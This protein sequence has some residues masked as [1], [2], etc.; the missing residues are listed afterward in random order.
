MTARIVNLEVNDSGAWRRVTSFDL[1]TK[2][3]PAGDLEYLT[4][5][6]FSLSSNPKLKARIIAPGEVAPLMIWKHGDMWREWRE[7]A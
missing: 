1:D 7:V 2:F 5:S 6:L 4:D 3:W